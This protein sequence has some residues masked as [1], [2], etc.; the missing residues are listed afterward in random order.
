MFNLKIKPD[1]SKYVQELADLIDEFNKGDERTKYGIWGNYLKNS[2]YHKRHNNNKED[3]VA[4]FNTSIFFKALYYVHNRCSN[5]MEPNDL[6]FE[7]TG[8]LGCSCDSLINKPFEVEDF[9]N[10]MPL[11]DMSCPEWHHC[12]STIVCISKRLY[13]Q[14]NP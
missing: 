12:R 11:V 6:L 10:N 13:K 8:R 4:S 5:G 9:L 7:V 1:R 2:V 14:R 3:I